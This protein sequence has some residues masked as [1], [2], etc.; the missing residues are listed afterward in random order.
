M[1]ISELGASRRFP[2][3]PAWAKLCRAALRPCRRQ[4]LRAKRRWF[5]ATDMRRGVGEGAMVKGRKD[6]TG[7][8][9]CGATHDTRLEAPTA[10]CTSLVVLTLWQ[11]GAQQAAPQPS[12]RVLGA[13]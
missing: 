3:L 8:C 11:V 12:I 7:G 10:K 4:D 13:V 5:G 2:G 1:R 6:F 9:R